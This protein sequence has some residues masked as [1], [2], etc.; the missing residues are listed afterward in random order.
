M[1]D[2]TKLEGEGPGTAAT[3]TTRAADPLRRSGGPPLVGRRRSRLLQQPGRCPPAR[4][5]AP[6]P[7]PASLPDFLSAKT[8][9][10]ASPGGAAAK[11]RRRQR[12]PARK[13]RQRATP[14]DTSPLFDSPGLDGPRLGCVLG[15]PRPRIGRDGPVHVPQRAERAAAAVQSRV[16]L[17]EYGVGVDERWKEKFAIW[18]VRTVDDPDV[19]A[20]GFYALITVCTHLGCTPNYLAAESKFKCPCHGSGF[21]LTGVNFGGPRR[22]RSSARASWLADEW[23]DPGRQEAVISTELGQ[24][25]D[26]EAFLKI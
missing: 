24:W 9:S 5:A 14:D 18:L 13:P 2:D 22:G 4:T 15:Q 10:G 11:G 20:G 6:R 12:P 1:A 25:T 16:P 19:H 23:S 26:P 3:G 7:S 8:T 21:R 17:N